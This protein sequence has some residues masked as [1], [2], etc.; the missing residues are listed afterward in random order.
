MLFEAK[1]G[2]KDNYK[3][4]NRRN[5]GPL[6]FLLQVNSRAEFAPLCD[7]GSLWA[8]ARAQESSSHFAPTD[9]NDH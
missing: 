1:L 2:E 5:G 3:G 8:R 4:N 7:W 6:L 9:S